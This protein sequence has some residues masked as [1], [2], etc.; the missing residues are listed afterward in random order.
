MVLYSNPPDRHVESSDKLIET[1]TLRDDLTNGWHL[2]H[3]LARDQMDTI[4]L[5]GGACRW[6]WL[7]R[8]ANRT[9][10]M[11]PIHKIAATPWRTT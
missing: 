5:R 10:E 9:Y 2:L 8:A 6:T 1:I 3:R 11:R 4:A 7:P